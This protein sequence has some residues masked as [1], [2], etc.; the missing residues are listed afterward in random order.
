MQLF[1]KRI[2]RNEAVEILNWKYPAPYNFYNNEEN[3]E[4]IRELLGSSYSV[5]IDENGRLIGFFCTGD[6]A[7]VPAG[8]KYG[9]YSETCTDIGLGMK[10]ELT[11]QGMG[12]AFFS[13]ILRHIHGAYKEVPLR[14]TVAKFN[15]RAIRLYEKLG[16]KRKIEFSNGST[17]FMTMIKDS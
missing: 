13:F 9:A 17:A 4:S 5:V 10:P 8:T 1:I 2:S 7:Q 6:S 16:F 15:D 11:G 3:E 14:L 12:Y